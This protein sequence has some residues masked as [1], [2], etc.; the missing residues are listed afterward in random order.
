MLQSSGITLGALT[1]PLR[2]FGFNNDTGI[3]YS[4]N[5]QLLRGNGHRVS[6]CAHISRW[7]IDVHDP[8]LGVT[9]IEGLNRAT[10][11]VP[12]LCRDGERYLNLAG[13]LYRIS[14]VLPGHRRV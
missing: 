2:Y 1:V 5:R 4:R 3:N 10:S 6:S 12:R 7:N 11:S 14:Q 8:D 13:V 9:R